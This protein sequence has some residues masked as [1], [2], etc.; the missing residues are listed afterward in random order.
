MVMES[1]ARWLLSHGKAAVFRTYPFVIILKEEKEEK[2]PES[3]TLKIDPGA[4]T[5]GMALLDSKGHVVQFVELEHRSQQIQK[6]L[7]TRKGARRNRRQRET[8]YRKPKWGNKTRKKDSKFCAYSPRPE[9]WLPPSVEASVNNIETW[10]KRF[11]KYCNLTDIYVE[12]VSFDTQKMDNPEIQ[13]KEYQ[14]GELCGYEIREYLLEKY[15]HKC[16]YCGGKTGDQVLEVEHKH[17]KGQGGSDK[18]SNLTLACHTCN[19]AKGNKTPKQWLEELQKKEDKIAKKQN[20]ADPDKEPKESLN[21]IRIKNI[22]KILKGQAVGASSRYCAWVNSS[23][24]KLLRMAERYEE[25][26]VSKGYIT[27]ANRI[28]AGLP[29]EHYYDALCVK[30]APKEVKILTSSV[31]C[32]KA[33][34]RGSHFRGRTN[35]CG[36]IDKRLPRQKEFFGF[37]TGD[38]VRA[39]VPKGKKAGTYTGKV[40]VRSS[41][42]FNIQTKEET[43]QGISHKYCRAIQKA[44]GYSY[45]F[46]PVNK[47]RLA[48]A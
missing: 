46:K 10:I 2:H 25:V 16:Q 7:E 9:G 11:Q 43:V 14:Q 42:Y 31:L 4:K 45:G 34:G 36:I 29:K 44:D 30:E 22:D 3:Y 33:T 32:I 6:N 21:Q 40:A 18:V 5:T 37:Q 41:G 19:Q 47:N 12:T 39:E 28:Q 13:G 23:R 35:A 27:R 8:R 48:N 38:M 20:D 17:P 15:Q 24:W 26:H 1:K